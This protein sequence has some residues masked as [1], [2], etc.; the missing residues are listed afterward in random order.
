MSASKGIVSGMVWKLLERFGVQTIQFILQL[1]LARLLD[2]ENYGVL[3]LMIVFINIATVFVQSGFNT[4]LIQNPDVSEDDYSSVFWV[5]LAIA[6]GL[7]A[8]LFFSATTIAS[9][10]DM[11]Q[12]ILPFRVL[13]LMLFPGALNSVQLAKVSREMDF[14]KVFYSNIGGIVISAGLGIVLAFK[15]FGLWALVAQT[16]LNILIAALVMIFTVDFRPRLVCDLR[17]VG[18]LF[19]FGWKL[20]AASLLDTVYLE[21]RSLVIGKKYT[22]E[23]LGY[24]NRGKQ[25]P[26]FAINGINGAVQSVMLPAM[27]AKQDNPGAV[28]DIMRRSVIV[29]SY[30]IFPLMG[31]LAGMS[32]PIIQLLLT[33]KWLPAVPYMQVYCF[34]MAFFP[35]HTCNLQAINAMGRSDVFLKLEFVKKLLGVGLL[36]VALIVFDSPIAIAL[37]GAVSAL[38]ST[39]INSYPNKVLIQYSYK[40][41]LQ[42]LLPQ[43]VLSILMALLVIPVQFLRVPTLLHIL[44]QLI[45]GAVFY[46]GVS[47]LFRFEGFKL[48][49]GMLGAIKMKRKSGA[50]K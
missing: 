36:I 35:I 6:T 8:V 46:L 50:T 44:L 19:S 10:Y 37:S 21:L 23:T 5:S 43:F 3:A 31:I 12:I 39:F 47:M 24:Y 7:Y 38:L 18:V 2:P 13:A 48:V 34:V 42:D 27:S 11:P 9:Y 1:V 33:D 20:M 40:E 26:Q 16:L 17:R 49:K 30:L 41:Q 32:R 45:L 29:S 15:G 28:R 4:S 14:R 22:A 25:F